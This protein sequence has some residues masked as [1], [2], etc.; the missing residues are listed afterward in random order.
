MNQSTMGI[1]K[2]G[3][4][5]GFVYIDE[6][7]EDSII[8]A[9][10]A[11]TDNFMGRRADGYEKPLVVMTRE[12]AEACRM[13]ADILRKQGYVL[14]FYDAYRPQRAVDDFCRWGD[15]LA[16]QRRK[17]VHYPNVEKVQMFDEGYIARKSGHTRGST[18]D[19]SIVDMKTHQEMDMGSIFDFMDPRSW[20]DCPDI[21]ELQ[22]KNRHILRDVMLQCGFRPYEK[23]WWHFTLKDEP[24]PTTYFDFLIS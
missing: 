18:V 21:T 16:D 20:P 11:G 14:I 10:Y 5:E 17:P 15:D 4:P 7:I 22:R 19:L 6:I 13:A 9:K 1:K 3:L 23:E 24:Y 8:D 12:A 2:A